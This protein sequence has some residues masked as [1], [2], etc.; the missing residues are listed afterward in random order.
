M[1]AFWPRLYKFCIGALVLAQM[2][3]L[4]LLSLKNAPGEFI[5]VLILLCIVLFF[6]HSVEKLF[7]RLGK[8]LPLTECER[9]DTLRD[10]QNYSYHFLDNVYV[11]PAM[12]ERHPIRA[13][14]RMIRDD[15]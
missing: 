6:H 8:Y 9:L 15:D 2:T 11:Q 5:C 13:E 3:L 1:G 7:P 12:N 4:G 14:Y 10:G